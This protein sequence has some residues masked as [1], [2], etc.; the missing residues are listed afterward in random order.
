MSAHRPAPVAPQPVRPVRA[1]DLPRILQIERA[2]FTAPWPRQAFEL[3]V[4]VPRILFLAAPPEPPILGYVVAVRD[5]DGVLIANLAVDPE[6]RRSGVGRGLLEAAVDW[7]RSLGAPCCHLE[8]RV[9]NRGAIELYRRAGF[10]PASVQRDY[11]DN[12]R[13]DALTMELPLREWPAAG[14]S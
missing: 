10:R 6:Q 11:Y 5:V 4:R 2:C 8:V 1:R 3:A 13:E 12:P 14:P 7:G 9:S